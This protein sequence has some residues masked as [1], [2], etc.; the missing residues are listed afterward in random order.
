MPLSFPSLILPRHSSRSGQVRLIIIMP[1]RLKM[2]I[3][4]FS[5]YPGLT[6]SSDRLL[7]RISHRPSLAHHQTLDIPQLVCHRILS[8]G[9]LFSSFQLLFIFVSVRDSEWFL[10]EV[11]KLHAF[12]WY[13]HFLSSFAFIVGRPCGLFPAKT[14]PFPNYTHF[15]FSQCGLFVYDVFWVFGTDVMVTVAKV[16]IESAH[17]FLICNSQILVQI[18]IQILFSISVF[19]SM[20]SSSHS[21]LPQ[22]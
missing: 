21:K 17:I 9:Q 2:S 4:R 12:S 13:A 1:K 18:S 19:I 3:F 20:L 16:S 14:C 11:S 6:S 5:G 10:S 8:T 15:L 22:N 7:Y